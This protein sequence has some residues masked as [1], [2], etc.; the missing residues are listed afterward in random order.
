MSASIAAFSAAGRV[1]IFS[2]RSPKPLFRSTPSFS[3]VAAC[4]ARRSLKK[5]SDG[6][7]EEDGVGDLHHGGLEVEREEDAVGLGLGDLLLV[8]GHEGGL[9]HDGGV[10]DLAGLEGVSAFRTLVVPSAA[11]NSIF[12][13]W[14]RRG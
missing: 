4:L 3:K 9:A 7:A 11:T 1:A 2:T 6:V 12:R 13:W 8:E 10:E 5:T 14:R